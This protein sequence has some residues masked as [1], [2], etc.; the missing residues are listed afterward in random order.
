MHSNLDIRS[1]YIN[2]MNEKFV[3]YFDF[4]SAPEQIENVEKFSSNTDQSIEDGWIDLVY[5]F[6][7]KW[8]SD[9]DNESLMDVSFSSNYGF[10]VIPHHLC[11]KNTQN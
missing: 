8:K 11:S 2:F 4:P 1:G 10:S 7:R 5:T 6:V 9:G 3:I